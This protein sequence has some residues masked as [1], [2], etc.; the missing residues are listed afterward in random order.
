MLHSQTVAGRPSVNARPQATK[1]H[2]Q[3][4]GALSH[5]TGIPIYIYIYSNVKGQTATDWYI[6]LALYFMGYKIDVVI[7]QYSFTAQC[8]YNS[9]STTANCSC[10]LR[11]QLLAMSTAIYKL[12]L[13]F[14]K[15]VV[16]ME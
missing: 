5:V 6:Y 12:D 1:P 11:S 16:L 10:S 2:T 8:F 7:G 3:K 15:F 14:I 13:E 4:H 9:H